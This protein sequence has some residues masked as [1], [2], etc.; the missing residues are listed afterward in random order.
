MEKNKKPI[1]T[2]IGSLDGATRTCIEMSEYELRE[3]KRTAMM[4]V[5]INWKVVKI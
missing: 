5:R 4:L 2:I 3:F 1:V